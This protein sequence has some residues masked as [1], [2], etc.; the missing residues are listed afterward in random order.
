VI[1]PNCPRPTG[2]TFVGDLQ[3]LTDSDLAAL[4]QR[5]GLPPKTLPLRGYDDWKRA[6]SS[7]GG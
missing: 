2:F 3:R 6:L 1:C 7:D 4:Q 5:I